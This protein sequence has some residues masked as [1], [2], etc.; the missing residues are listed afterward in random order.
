[1]SDPNGMANEGRGEGRGPRGGRGGGASFSAARGAGLVAAAVIV[2]IVLLQVIDDGNDGPVG[3]GSTTTS[4]TAVATSTPSDTTAGDT[5]ATTKPVTPPAEVSVLVL[6]GSGRAGVASTLTNE[7]KAKGY[8]TLAPSNAPTQA[9][10]DVDFKAGKTAECTT[11]AQSV[12]KARV[13]P[14]PNPPPAVSE[15]DCIVVIGT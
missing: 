7:L 8:K 15:A 1:M 14:M 3:D 4:S 12:A 13:K 5:T 10:T 11:L 6:N 2:G 9:G